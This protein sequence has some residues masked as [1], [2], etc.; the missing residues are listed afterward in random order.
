[1]C[2]DKM[3]DKTV[4]VLKHSETE[5]SASKTPACAICRAETED[6]VTTV[7]FS[8]VGFGAL[9][10]GNY[11]LYVA[12]GD[13][14]LFSRDLGKVPSSVAFTF[15]R[16]E[17]RER[18]I[19]AGVWAVKDDLP[20]LVA[21]GKS[22]NAR[23]SRKD[24]CSAV[25]N[26]VL[27]RKKIREKDFPY[28]ADEKND[29][30][31]DEKGEEV[32][33]AR[34]SAVS[35]DGSENTCATEDLN[36]CS[37]FFSPYDDEAVATE[38][39][40]GADD[41]IREKL[42]SVKE[43]YDEYFRRE[44]RGDDSHRAQEKDEIAENACL[45]ENETDVKGGESDFGKKVTAELNAL[46]DKYPE[47]ENLKKIFPD[48][49]WAKVFYAEEKFYVVGVIKEDGKEKYICYGVPSRYSPEPPKELAGY[50]SFIPLSIFDLKGDGYFMMFQDAVSGKCVHIN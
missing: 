2:G 35:L 14:T 34:E 43:K 44:N 40:Y 12:F 1:M 28:A 11:V 19:A 3:F 31:I 9:A 26:D 49:R 20:L 8:P 33:P 32:S 39:F 24:Y 42:F 25:I 13:K 45:S 27:S 17:T 30:N 47:E 21:Y 48:S 18:D 5:F 7:Y 16:E 29:G 46:F 41:K 36:E 23:F 37:L 4:I 22:E 50:C 10:N 38:N 15:R 6:G